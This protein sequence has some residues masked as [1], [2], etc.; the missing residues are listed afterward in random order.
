MTFAFT[1]NVP[2]IIALHYVYKLYMKLT[3]NSFTV[4]SIILMGAMVI[5]NYLKY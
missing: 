3:K 2:I 5:N 4:R 1:M